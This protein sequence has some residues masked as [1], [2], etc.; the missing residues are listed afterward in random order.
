MPEPRTNDAPEPTPE[1]PAAGAPGPAGGQAR[2]G[3]GVVLPL[4]LVGALAALA[5]VAATGLVTGPPGSRERGSAPPGPSAGASGLPGASPVASD[6]SSTAPP[7]AAR[8]GLIAVVDA[9]GTLTTMNERGGSVVSYAVSGVSFGSPTW[10]PDGSRIAAIGSTASDT[11]IYVFTVRRAAS[12]GA[13]GPVV[14]YRSSNRPAFYLYWTPDSRSVSFLATEPAELSLRIAPADGSAP[15]DGSGPGAI[16]RRGAPLYFDWEDADRLL[17]HVG[18]GSSSFVGDVGLDGSPVAPAIDGRGDFRAPSASDDGRYLAY[19]RSTTASSGEIVVAARD[20]TSQHGLPVFGPAAF[21]FGPAA[22]TLASIGAA[23]SGAATTGFPM[24]PLRLVDAR[25]GDARTLV[26]GSVVGFFWAPDGRTIAAL[27]LARPGDQTAQGIPAV[28]TAARARP[29]AAA[30]PTPGA[31][32]RLAFI[33]VAT[34][35]LR[36]ERVVQPGVGFVDQI[37]P[38]FDQYALSHRV[39]A[40]DS[41]SIVLPLVDATGRA[42]IVVLPADGTDSRTIAHG[43][44]AFWSP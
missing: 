9:N 7:S 23:T 25:T 17:L 38:Y 31:E 41:A 19:V 24:G 3:R 11:S 42:Q 20:G 5:V 34:G 27:R 21:G 12:S 36:S 29:V 6:A 15:L 39:W 35:A 43:E 30:T 2:G 22:D 10:S 16:I 37:L 4:A 33:D 14:I 44:S 26:E 32:V 18:T 13:V 8:D 40:P 1:T 28:T